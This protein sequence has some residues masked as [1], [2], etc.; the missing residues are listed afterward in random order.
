MHCVKYAEL[1]IRCRRSGVEDLK[2]NLGERT[3]PTEKS[4]DEGRHFVHGFGVGDTAT[5]TV[6]RT[7]DAER[8]VS[9]FALDLNCAG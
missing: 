3:K 6:A 7:L 5:V 1:L 8:K 9:T 4:A 2:V